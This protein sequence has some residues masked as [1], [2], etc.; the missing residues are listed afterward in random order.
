MQNR[1]R[2]RADLAQ[3][4]WEWRERLGLTQAQVAAALG[5]ERRQIIKYELGDAPVP[6]IVAL[7][8][9][10]L[11]DHPELIDDAEATT[12]AASAAL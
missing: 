12:P 10:A 8:M 6:R 4:F 2:R 1:G 11:E 7:A 3:D 9:V 5:R